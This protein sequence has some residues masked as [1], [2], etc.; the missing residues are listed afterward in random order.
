M[1]NSDNKKLINELKALRDK[2]NDFERRKNY[3]AM[4]EACNAILALDKRAKSLNIMTC[5]YYKDLGTAYLKLLEYDKALA[6][7]TAARD[8]LVEY[9]S[10]QML[11]HPDD[12]LHELGA[13]ERLIERVETVHLKDVW[14]KGEE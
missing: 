10:T 9:R 8:G 5:L 6:S 13:I 11:K 14:K 2:L 12:W 4:V 1:A 3:P 7:F